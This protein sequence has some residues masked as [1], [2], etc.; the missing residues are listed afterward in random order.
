MKKRGCNF[1]YYY[2]KQFFLI[3]TV[4]FLFHIE[5]T[6]TFAQKFEHIDLS[7][8]VNQSFT[9]EQENDGKGWADF[10]EDACF[11]K[12]PYGIVAFEDGI[13]PFKII[14]PE[15]NKGK[16]AL[17][18]S[19]PK[20]EE[21]FPKISKQIKINKEFE[22][23]FF[24]HTCMY[25]K[26]DS[27]D[28]VKYRI[29]YAD[30]TEVL[31]V[32]NNNV[33]IAD[34]WEPTEFLPKAERT[35][36]E[37]HKWLINTPWK[38]PHPKKTIKWIEM[39][40]TGNAIP[41]LVA[42]SGT[43]DPEPYEKLVVQIKGK[44]KQYERSNIT[45]AL[46]QIKSQP[47]TALN[48]KKGTDFCR[49]AAKNGAD[50]AMFPELYNIGYSGVDFEKPDVLEK[51]HRKAITRDDDFIKHFQ[52]L[53]KELN[54][55][56]VFSY[57][58]DIGEDKLPRNSASL[59]DRHGNIVFTYAKIHTAEFSHLENL[60]TPGNDFYVKELD[61]KAGP[62]KTGIMICYDREFPES[63]RTLML[64]GA[65]IILTPNACFLDELRLSQFRVR[66]ME[67]AVATAMTNYA[68]TA[69]K[70]FNGH[71]CIFNA[72]AN[73]VIIAGEDEGIY[74]GTVNMH[75]IR[76]YRKETIWGNAFRR[77]QKYGK[78]VSPEVED[79]FNRKDSFGNE[80][81]RL[82]R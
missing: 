75:D 41:V 80:F 25:V 26:K 50:I 47:D 31:F 45:I 2:S 62:V 51:W 56:I 78:L 3:L 22:S 68:K 81:K 18:L 30:G 73:K 74:Y 55:A 57:L 21:A 46:L 82:E 70:M 20:R 39:Q 49:E 67:N 58:E 8:Y 19:G 48:F 15:K 79:V 63:A 12:L 13:V 14:N 59:I 42:I 53:A 9:D 28:L 52:N 69:N 10:G 61:T 34:W 5:T 60:T 33:E 76:K 54:M 11:Y 16:S 72:D 24:L 77:P 65:E 35:Y 27:K 32:C 6:E 37:S 64:K 38:N 7:K 43:K 1:Q 44:I 71:S 36:E 4:I 23:L 17:V 66:A 29:H 40:S